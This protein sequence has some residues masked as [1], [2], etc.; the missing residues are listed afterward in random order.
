MNLLRVSAFALYMA[1]ALSLGG[2]ATYVTPGAAA[3]FHAMG[4]SK[5][6][7]DNLS[8]MDV[9][10]AMNRKPAAAFPTAIVLVRLQGDSYRSAT[11]SG[12]GRGRY[13]VV[14]TREVEKD[15][16]VSRLEKLPMIRT[17]GTLNRLVL[18]DVINNGRD[19]RVAAAN[20]QADIV[21]AYTFDTRFQEGDTT[22]PALGVISLGLFP[23]E[24]QRATS[25]ASA[26]FIDTRTGFIYGLCEATA[27][28]ERLSNA[29]GSESALD[30]ARRYAE[31][32]AF[33]ALV[34]QMEATWKGIVAQYGPGSIEAQ[35]H[36]PGIDL[37]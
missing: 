23:N 32:D 4:I 9:E 2:C 8:D 25:T 13:T 31:E 37:K 18:P 15:E 11:T 7:A 20:V 27:K 34:G 28:R 12:Y 14:T 35:P 5:A 33:H 10:M 3:D 6:T 29:W 24:V 1:A 16:D 22:I 17:L 21:V 26:A 19:L 36:T 30:A